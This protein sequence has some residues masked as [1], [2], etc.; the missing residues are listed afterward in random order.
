[1]TPTRLLTLALFAAAS[2][3]ALAVS[4]GQFTAGLSHWDTLG[5][6]VVQGQTLLLTSAFDADDDAAGNFNFSGQPAAMALSADGVEVFAGLAIGALDGD[7]QAAEGSVARQQFSVQAGDTLHFDWQLLT[8]E[9]GTSALPDLGFAVLNGQ[10]FSLAEALA[11]QAPGEFGLAAGTGWQRF[12]Y[13]FSQAG[14]AS[15]AFGVV[16]R[17]DFV[18]TSALAVQNVTVTPVPEPAAWALVLAGAGVLL[19]ARRRG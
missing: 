18:T 14:L 13:T 8:N 5:D 9:Q 7:L 11:A 1:M 17:G 19:M 15:L 10:L 16:D 6:A 2:S 3:P 12:S 4:N